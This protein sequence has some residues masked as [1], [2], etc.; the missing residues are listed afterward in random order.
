M[1][2]NSRVKEVVTILF[3]VCLITVPALAL[4][5]SG[6]ELSAGSKQHQGQDKKQ[7]EVMKKMKYKEGQII[8]KFKHE[9]KEENRKLIR[10][11]HGLRKLKTHAFDKS[12]LLEI[13]GGSS[14][15][16]A[17]LRLKDNPNVLHVQPNFV[18]QAAELPND[19]NF[20]DLWGLNN[21]GQYIAGPRTLGT[22]VANID[23]DAPEAWDITQGS[24]DIVVGVIDT[25]IDIRHIDLAA[26]IWT[27]PGEIIGDN[28]DNDN[29]GFVDD[30]H[31]W[32]FWSGMPC[33]FGPSQNYHGTH[34]AGTIA[35]LANNGEGVTGV[36]PKVKILP[37]QFLG[38]EGYGYTSDA[39]DALN[40]AQMMGVK[41]TNNS[42]GG[43]SYDAELHD[44][45]C[46]Y[47]GVFVA[48]AG[49]GS[50]DAD[51][52]PHYPAA[53]DCPNIVS[54]AALNNRGDLAS[55]STYGSTTVD[56][57]APGEDIFSTMPG[58]SY[59]YLSGTSMASPHVTGI[60][61]LL[62]SM[63]PGLSGADVRSM[64]IDTA[65]PLDS[66]QGR[67][68]SGGM[69]SAFN[70]VHLLELTTD[71]KDK[72]IEVPQDKIITITY[73]SDV[74]QGLSFDAITLMKGDQAVPL[75]KVLNGRSLVLNPQS[76][77]ETNSTYTVTIPIGA[78]KNGTGLD[79]RSYS[80][81][82]Q[83][84]D[85][86]A[87][88]VVS[89]DPINSS[90][91]V[92]GSQA[93]IIVLN[94]PA[95]L[96]SNYANISLMKGTVPVVTAVSVVKNVLTI[97]P[98]YSLEKTTTYT[99]TIPANAV[100]DLAG[101]PLAALSLGFTTADDVT[102]PVYLSVTPL[103]YTREVPTDTDITVLFSENVLLDSHSAAIFVD[104]NGVKSQLALSVNGSVLTIHPTKPLPSNN[105]CLMMVPEGSVKD[106]VGN[107]LV[108]PGGV[109]FWTRDD[110][111]PK[112]TM[113]DPVNGSINVP[114]T[115]W[116]D[117]TFTEDIMPG[118]NFSGIT[119][120][121]ENNI[122]VPVSVDYKLDQ[123]WGMTYAWIMTVTPLEVMG[124]VKKYTVT[125]P[126][127]AITD[128]S[129]QHNPAPGFQSSFTTVKNTVAPMANN[130]DPISGG[131]EV[132]TNKVITVT[133][134]EKVVPG[135]A[136]AGIS[137]KSGSTSVPVTVSVNAAKLTITPTSL[138]QNDTTYTVNVP[139]AAVAD[140]AGNPSTVAVVFSFK[141][142]D[143]I[144]PRVVGTYPASGAKNVSVASNVPIWL[145]EDCLQGPNF[146]AITIK[147]QGG[148]PVPLTSNFFEDEEGAINSYLIVTP[149]VGFHYNTVYTV[150]IP[151][152]AVVDQKGNASLP[153][154]F[155]F[156]TS[157][158]VTGS[159]PTNGAIGVA[160][161]KTITLSLNAPGI[162]DSN[163]SEISLK[164]GT[165]TVP[166]TVTL[167]DATITIQPTAGLLTNVV[168]TVNVPSGA[169]VSSA[170]IAVASYSSSFRT[171]DPT[172]PKVT[173][174]DPVNGATGVPTN[175]AIM[176]NFS[177]ST[178]RGP[179]FSAITI[180]DNG[181]N[182]VPLTSDY[183]CDDYGCLDFVLVITP[184]VPL[185]H[186]K[187]YNVVLPVG[188]LQDLG[189][190]NTEPYT[191]GFQT[192]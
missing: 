86:I 190:N 178:V 180:S 39:L 113:V 75:T 117:V 114:A 105:L 137:L 70:A 89:T 69:A 10:E 54:V 177:E 77:M 123:Y 33:V 4:A 22:G 148:N 136:F 119:L 49:N 23:I 30:V 122:S 159:D 96:G 32:N 188:T 116:M 141:T 3:L 125:F 155:S 34:V 170:G 128:T 58:N 83:T 92:P 172:I 7:S 67:T 129:P 74:V 132:P 93:I 57:G 95:K 121:D 142:P 169:V 55:F 146:G 2:Y 186:N 71:P 106:A 167:S 1:F 65:K 154:S 103:P 166:A 84:H 40:Y 145:S 124:S 182:S 28:I 15:E 165:T 185:E 131:Y 36:A 135:T 134:N 153:Y 184:T 139:T 88:Q 38:P 61:A 174:T 73:V 17:M 24:P 133:F 20:N 152:G 108:Y 26:N 43:G 164:K 161:N 44:A 140:L 8:V 171:I 81:S 179:N 189:G 6:A 98:V 14:V 66:L 150:T 63:Q 47:D 138:L 187:A 183:Y 82:F 160:V 85:T 126:A 11:K 163:F 35:A 147:D 101:N 19:P 151:A 52:S 115:K 78:V 99:V 168:Y 9:T 143:T 110:T 48:A 130:S 149:S 157:Y 25:D 176:V 111:P 31:G 50:D 104:C 41:V 162:M 16:T 46:G 181:G 90:I 158:L 60:A 112:M 59:G 91:A 56:V 45:I 42:W 120:I 64:L 72:A 144:P 80:F 94:E 12:E 118:P 51:S 53:F 175:A 192:Q 21:L 68:V 27:N 87:P 107:Y 156:S 109:Y 37:L 191:L 18:Y 76:P 62:L 79:L 29:N 173:S 97:D 102:P 5:I 13:T 127:G 100:T